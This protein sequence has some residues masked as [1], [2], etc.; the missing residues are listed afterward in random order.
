MSIFNRRTAV[1]IHDLLM[2]NF[3]WGLAITLRYLFQPPN[4]IN[5][6]DLNLQIL[7]IIIIIQSIIFWHY[8]LYKGIWRFASIP[9]LLNI[10]RAAILG[11]LVISL[12]LILLN[13]LEG[14]PRSSL[15]LYP[16]FLSILLGIPRLLYRLWREHSFHFLLKS[17][18]NAKRV[19]IIG[20]GL[21][22]EMLARDML[23]NQEYLP[24]AFLDK[25]QRLH[26]ARVHS[27]PVLGDVNKLSECVTKLNI[28]LII[29]AIPSAND[30]EMQT[31]VEFCEQTKVLF[32]TL[33]K[34]QDMYNNDKNISLNSLKNV[35]IEDLLGRE[36]ISLDWEIIKEG[37]NNKI[38][39]ISGGGGSIG[40]EL[41]YQIVKLQPK[42]IIIFEQCEF[43][44]YK[45]DLH[46][47]KEFP[48]IKIHSCLGDICDRRA[49]AH[50][51]K[52]YKPE[53]IFHAAAYKHV[54][55][56]QFQIREAANNNI[57][58]T[59]ILAETAI[60]Y[61]CKSF[62]MI[63]T[64][65]AVNPTSIMGACKRIAEI[66]CQCLNGNSGTNFITVRFG[67]VLGSAGSVVPL[68]QKQITEGGPVTVTHPDIT[69]YFM[70][71][72]E[73]CEL[74]LQAGTISHGGEIFVLDMGIPIKISYLAEQLIKLSGKIPN[75]D[76]KI[77]Y[78]GLRAGEK[79]YEE[80][81]HM[82]EEA[83]SRTKHDKIMLA[84]HRNDYELV[85]VTEIL[86]K[87]SYACDDYNVEKIESFIKQ[88]VPEYIKH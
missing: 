86:E 9:D 70:T 19:L 18:A 31:I 87:I 41:C 6:L 53:I 73:A 71:I 80:L 44:L 79:L 69:R 23:R 21:S 26:G 32:R 56:L 57:L 85:Q 40:A 3:A 36:K 54:P 37:L 17:E 55:M 58:G 10:S 88:L 84:S 72:P 16:I 77:V 8:D 68:F 15:L 14:I 22:G 64:D 78:T 51:I 49:V 5:L 1:V 43:N 48:D 2:I 20:A 62:V 12:C 67:N 83:R 39:M 27:I 63:S 50:V 28:E 34:L 30:I 52:T 74:I 66:Y 65:K 29:I 7:P 76:I 38:V 81:F 82:E 47:A 13:R 4:E 60:K 11:A 35:C 24:I 75:K 61:N 42:S 46:L 33:P 25:N 59:Q 45:I